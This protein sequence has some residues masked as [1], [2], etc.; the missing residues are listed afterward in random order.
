MSKKRPT[1]HKNISL[2]DAARWLEANG[3]K[4]W[5]DK[6]ELI[7]WHPSWANRHRAHHANKDAGRKLYS[8][9]RQVERDNE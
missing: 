8:K 7:L 9:L 5:K 1:L 4:T 2:K 3:G 6:G